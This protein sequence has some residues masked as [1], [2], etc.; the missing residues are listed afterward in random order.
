MFK[1]ESESDVQS[2]LIK[3]DNSDDELEKTFMS[4]CPP[5]PINNVIKNTE[6]SPCESDNE[7]ASSY[8]QKIKIYNKFKTN[9]RSNT[10]KSF[11]SKCLSHKMTPKTE[12]LRFEEPGSHSDSS[13][14]SHSYE[15]I[16]NHKEI[17]IKNLN[18]F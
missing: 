5:F 9:S 6:A 12:N 11:G 13:K 8:I 7:L 14:D 18:S 10:G 3:D 4:L 15:R 16:I 17:I 2:I 1:D